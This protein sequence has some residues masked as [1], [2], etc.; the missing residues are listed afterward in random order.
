MDLMTTFAVQLPICLVL[1]A[2]CVFALASWRKHPRVSALA[3]MGSGGLLLLTVMFDFV[4]MWL[5][6][7]LDAMGVDRS[8]AMGALRLTLGYTTTATDR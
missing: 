6:Q 5:P 4:W 3:C 1:G 7:Y 8:L 2:G